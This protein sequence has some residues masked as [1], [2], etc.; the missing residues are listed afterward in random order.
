MASVKKKSVPKKSVKKADKKTA[1][2]P[3]VKQEKKKY[4]PIKDR[5][6]TGQPEFT[7]MISTHA[8]RD[9]EDSARTKENTLLRN[10]LLADDVKTETGFVD[11]NLFKNCKFVKSGEYEQSRHQIINE[12]SKRG[13][14]KKGIIT[15][16]ALHRDTK[17]G[18]IYLLATRIRVAARQMFKNKWKLEQIEIYKLT[19]LAGKA[20][21]KYQDMLKLGKK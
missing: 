17:E 2:K 10:T 15:F 19:D 5:K 1:S 16:P 14:L 4:I 9:P 7:G 20:K 3:K 6:L 11:L 12:L 18:D 21:F 8:K 13:F